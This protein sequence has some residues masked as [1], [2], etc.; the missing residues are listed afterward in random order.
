[1]DEQHAALVDATV[2]ELSASAWEC[3]TEATFN[4]FGER[5]SVDILAFHPEARVLL[6]VEVK[7]TIPDIGNLLIPLDRKL[8]LAPRLAM[9]RGWTALAFGRLLVVSEGSVNRR[10]IEAHAAIFR[11]A[12]PCRGREVRDWLV[13]PAPVAR[14]SGLW[15]LGPGLGQRLVPER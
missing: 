7:S 11:S 14:W 6:V 13:H 8:R 10:R 3:V 15:L 2:A 1:V 12:F 9:D 4:V 5:G